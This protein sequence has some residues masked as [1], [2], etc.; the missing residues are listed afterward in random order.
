MSHST[1]TYILAV[2]IICSSSAFGQ[3]PRSDTLAHHN[4]IL[5]TKKIYQSIIGGNA[6]VFN[7]IEYIDPLHKKT[8]NGNA[9]FLTDE[10]QEGFLFYDDQFYEQV[11]LQYN[12][13]LNKVIIEH[14]QSH[15]SIELIN[16][17]IKYFGIGNH[18]FVRLS[19]LPEQSEIKEGFYD[20]LADGDTKVYVRRYKTIKEVAGQKIMVTEFLDKTRLFLFKD[21]QYTAITNK[22]S[23][24]NAFGKNKPELKKFLA[25][26]KIN[27]RSNPEIAM[28]ALASHYDELNK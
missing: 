6:T 17:K 11:S 7:G 22:H 25:Q 15:A 10:W 26:E 21:E 8:L 28:I 3:G 18:I 2:L 24:L 23:A 27:F 4:A 1:A 12:L 20:V 19:A 16:D 13:F 5:L 14:I 9:C